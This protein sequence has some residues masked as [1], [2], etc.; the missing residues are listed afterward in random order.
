MMNVSRERQID[1]GDAVYFG[2][3]NDPRGIQLMRI[4][5]LAEAKSA[6]IENEFKNLAI[7]INTDAVRATTRTT[8]QQK[9]LH[10]LYLNG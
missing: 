2:M 10:S 9:A 1:Y 3:P 5:E 4:R 8:A 6:Q 7:A